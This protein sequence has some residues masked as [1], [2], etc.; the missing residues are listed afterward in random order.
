MKLLTAL[1]IFT[2]FMTLGHASEFNASLKLKSTL[3]YKEGL[4]PMVRVTGKNV[5]D[6]INVA[7]SSMGKHQKI[8]VGEELYGYEGEKFSC[9]DIK[10]KDAYCVFY[11]TSF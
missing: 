11:V 8:F 6:I 3:E 2:Q 10:S 7:N 1:F 9:Y 4:V 5:Q